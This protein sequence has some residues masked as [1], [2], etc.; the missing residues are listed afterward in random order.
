MIFGK[1][2]LKINLKI[3]MLL[4][5]NGTIGSWISDKEERLQTFQNI[6]KKKMM[7]K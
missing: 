2:G 7:K 6:L 5:K 4:I 3:L 1:C